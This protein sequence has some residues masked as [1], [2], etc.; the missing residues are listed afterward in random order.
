MLR[1]LSLPNMRTRNQ[2]SGVGGL[3]R[4]DG[5]RLLGLAFLLTCSCRL[6]NPAFRLV[7][8]D[9]DAEC[10]GEQDDETECDENLGETTAETGDASTLSVDE[11]ATQGSSLTEVG[12]A[13]E[14]SNATQ[15]SSSASSN[16]SLSSTVSSDAESSSDAKPSFSCSDGPSDCF[17]MRFDA[18]SQTFV[19]LGPGS[20][21][22]KKGTPDADVQLKQLDSSGVFKN[23]FVFK[24]DGYGIMTEELEIDPQVSLGVEVT[25]RNLGCMQNAKC[26]FLYLQGVMSIGYD[27]GSSKVFCMS[28]NQDFSDFV[29]PTGQ[30][31]RISCLFEQQTIKIRVNGESGSVHQTEN[32][33]RTRT[34]LSIGPSISPSIPVVQ[35]AKAEVGGVKIWLDATSMSSNT[36]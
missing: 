3:C 14:S 32:H 33:N 18:N 12:T 30:A 35:G 5:R 7:R 2:V 26:Y 17:D 16:S 21:V 34:V 1:L 20:A 31:A 4:G 23:A 27:P 8:S 15:S 29:L 13:G 24:G 11:T 25:V 36:P 9:P 22:L 19:H 6:D 10:Q 28:E